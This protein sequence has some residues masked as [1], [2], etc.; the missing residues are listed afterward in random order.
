VAHT[1][2]RTRVCVCRMH[3][4]KYADEAKAGL[5][6]G[7]FGSP[8]VA[9][10]CELPSLCLRR[11][12]LHHTIPYH[13]VFIPTRVVNAGVSPQRRKDAL[14]A[15]WRGAVDALRERREAALAAKA[16]VCLYVCVCVY[17]RVCVCVCV[18]GRVRVLAWDGGVPSGS[19]RSRRHTARPSQGP[20]RT[21]WPNHTKLL[22]TMHV[23][24]SQ[25]RT[26]CVTTC[27]P[28]GG[29]GLR[30]RAHSALTL[31]VAY[32]CSCWYH[33][34]A[35]MNRVLVASPKQAELDYANARTQ[36]QAER[37]ERSIKDSVAALKVRPGGPI[38][39]H[40]HGLGGVC[41]CVYVRVRVAVCM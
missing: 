29:A 19:G 41:D 33:C 30:Q 17:G 22:F 1:P 27:S 28:P 34:Y 38:H 4:S 39:T 21:T 2:A 3:A 26:I 15:E 31:L 11:V 18:Y 7:R 40:A 32:H 35:F 5:G 6:R 25:S 24:V 14:V 16:Q 13:C 12:P 36:Q 20:S 8:R 9:G 10:S 23:V 37:A